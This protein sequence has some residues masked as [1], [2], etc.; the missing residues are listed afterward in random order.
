MQPLSNLI[1]TSQIQRGDRIRVT[2]GDGS[3][4]LK[5]F[6]EAGGLEERAAA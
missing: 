1:S 6:R 2:H 5:F 3:P 4:M